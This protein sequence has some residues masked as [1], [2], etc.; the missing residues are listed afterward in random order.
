MVDT[1]RQRA[2]VPKV[3]LPRVPITS[4]AKT[5]ASPAS[6]TAIA[7]PSVQAKD[8]AAHV[9]ERITIVNSLSQVVAGEIYACDSELVL[10][11]GPSE[12]HIIPLAKVTKYEIIPHESPKAGSRVQGSKER[13]TRLVKPPGVSN[14]GHKIFLA[15][16][17]TLP[18]RWH[19]DSI[20]V[21]D[22]VLIE[23]PYGVH[24]CKA[25]AKQLKQLERVK[26]LVK[27]ELAKMPNDTTIGRR[28]G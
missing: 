3:A 16:A 13:E 10:S 21:L 25:P 18:V 14:L 7:N 5:S 6:Q 12:Y 8:L 15:L 20:I 9:G 22:N 11:T 19:N 4:L 1:V 26:E 17:K 28:G 2:P 23:P 24:N 27:N